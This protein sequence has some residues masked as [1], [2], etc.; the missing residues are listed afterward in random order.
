MVII[1]IIDLISFLTKYFI[2][3]TI[4]IT[5][6]IIIIIIMKEKITNFNN[7][8]MEIIKAYIRSL[9][10]ISIMVLIIIIIIF[11]EM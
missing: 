7:K 6:K 9:R 1:F 4:D 11:E 8:E 2:K 3:V 5:N 10:I